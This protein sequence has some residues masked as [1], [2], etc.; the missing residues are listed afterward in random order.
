MTDTQEIKSDQRVTNALIMIKLEAMEKKLDRVDVLCDNITRFDE[1]W[2][3]HY[4]AHSA[5]DSK[6]NG[7]DSD[8]KKWSSAGGIVGAIF[9]VLASLGLNQK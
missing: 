3:A 6:M 2:R 1:R 4:S 5:L 7:F 9:A 8:I